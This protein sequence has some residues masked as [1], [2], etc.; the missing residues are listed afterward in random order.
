MRILTELNIYPVKSLGGISLQESVVQPRGLQYDR[1]WMLVDEQGRFVSQREVAEMTQL[2][3][4]I[5]PPFL[6]VFSKKNPASRVRIPLEPPV[7]EMP[8]ITVTIWDDHCT[9][10]VHPPEINTWF[11]DMLGLP[12]RLVFMPDTTV[13]PTDP[14]YA[15]EGLPVSFSDGFPFLLI[16]RASLD[17]L[18][19]RLAEPLPMDR[20]RPNFVFT[21]GTPYEEDDWAEFSIGSVRFRGVKPCARCIITT[22]D[23][24]TGARAAEPLKTLATYRKHGNR[25]LFG[26][27]VLWEAG[28]RD[29]V[30][31]GMPVESQ[32][33]KR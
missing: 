2:G 3:T 4:A 17:D 1:R 23:Q 15:P 31:V 27:N 5:E 8:E 25:I 7:S 19:N 18:N 6:V 14:K 24:E 11:S 26:Q 29:I 9:A 28:S 32:K 13:R 33:V 16:G 12:L 20:F 22:T 10:R 21:G 30:Q